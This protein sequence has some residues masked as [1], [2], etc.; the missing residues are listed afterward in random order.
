MKTIAQA[1]RKRF[2]ALVSLCPMRMSWQI[3]RDQGLGDSGGVEH[4]TLLLTLN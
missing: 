1:R 4:Q 3:R 2:L